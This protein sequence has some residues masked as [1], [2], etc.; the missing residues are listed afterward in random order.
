MRK[1]IPDNEFRAWLK[2]ARRA[3]ALN[4]DFRFHSRNLQSFDFAD[5][6]KLDRDGMLRERVDETRGDDLDLIYLSFQKEVASKA[7]YRSGFWKGWRVSVGE[8]GGKLAMSMGDE[9]CGLP[10]GCDKNRRLRIEFSGRAKQ[11]GV[12]CPAQALVRTHEYDPTFA[13]FP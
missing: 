6:K 5:W 13:D 9:L 3:V 2:Q 1:Q 10:P 7:S 8:L 4:V 12:Q 11:V